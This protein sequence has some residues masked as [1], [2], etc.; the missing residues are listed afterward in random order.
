MLKGFWLNV[1][2]SVAIC[3][4]GLSC[5]QLA[6]DLVEPVPV[7][8]A[9]GCNACYTKVFNTQCGGGCGTIAPHCDDCSPNCDGPWPVRDENGEI[10]EYECLCKLKAP[11]E[12]VFP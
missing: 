8:C 9:G 6:A 3:L 10:I 12:P 4:G 1:L 5:L 7:G 11:T 2:F